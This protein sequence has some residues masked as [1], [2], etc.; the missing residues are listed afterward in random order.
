[1]PSANTKPVAARIPKDHYYLLLREAADRQMTIS[2]F[3]E[4]VVIKSYLSPKKV[5]KAEGGAIDVKPKIKPTKCIVF[6]EIP[7]LIVR[8]IGGNYSIHTIANDNTISGGTLGKQI[9][10]GAIVFEGY[11][12]CLTTTKEWYE[13]NRKLKNK[14]VEL[15]IIWK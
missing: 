11:D 10:N 9:A 7:D 6:D 4:D 5:Q 15:E 12:I 8:N 2:R 3:L 1:M 13:K 14:E